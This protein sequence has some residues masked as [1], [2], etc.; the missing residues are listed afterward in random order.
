MERSWRRRSPRHPTEIT[1][2]DGVSRRSTR[3]RHSSLELTAQRRAEWVAEAAHD[4]RGPIGTLGSMLTSV[5][6]LHA[7]REELRSLAVHAMDVAESVLRDGSTER[8]PIDLSAVVER[9]CASLERDVAGHG[10]RLIWT[11][12][13]HVSVMGVALDLRRCVSNLVRNAARFSPPG[14]AVRVDL[15]TRG[16]AAVLTVQ[17]DGPGI[18]PELLATLF[19]RGIAGNAAQSQTGLGLSIVADRVRRLG[20]QIEASNT[21]KGGAVFTVQLPR[22]ESAPT[23]PVC[24]V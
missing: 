7:E 19:Q 22:C 9:S 24:A 4:I 8:Q 1:T 2:H 12:N 20:G 18:P 5:D 21:A 16:R 15:T 10:A 11:C 23:L 13:P 17:D 14:G 3:R 6:D